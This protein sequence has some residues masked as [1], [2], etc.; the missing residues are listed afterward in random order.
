MK[1]FILYIN[2]FLLLNCAAQGTASGG[3][4]DLEGPKLLSI[5]PPNK[6]Q[7][8]PLDQKIVL[9]FNELIDPIS[10]QNAVKVSHAHTIKARGRHIIIKPK[11]KRAN[12]RAYN[13]L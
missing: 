6:S 8:I 13:Y 12:R 9:T 2:I 10:I 3:P 5:D 1:F 11:K 4:E 7:N